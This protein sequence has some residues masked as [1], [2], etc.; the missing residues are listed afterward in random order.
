MWSQMLSISCIAVRASRHDN[1]ESS[2]GKQ[3]GG[4]INQERLFKFQA[5][6]FFKFHTMTVYVET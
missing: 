6:V 3:R 2:H 5:A 4:F 1:H